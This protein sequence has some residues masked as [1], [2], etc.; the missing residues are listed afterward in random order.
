MLGR[1]LSCLLA[2]YTRCWTSSL[3][4]GGRS[5][6]IGRICAGYCWLTV[7]VET[8][9]LLVVFNWQVHVFTLVHIPLPLEVLL[10]QRQWQNQFDLISKKPHFDYKPEFIFFVFLFGK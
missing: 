3:C 4:S 8:V 1:E 2:Y 10:L 5:Y 7:M 6:N 9:F